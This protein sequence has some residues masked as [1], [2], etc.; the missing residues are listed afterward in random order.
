MSL[1]AQLSPEAQARLEAQKRNSTISSIAISILSIILLGLILGL[2]LL[3]VQTKEVPVL[4]TYEVPKLEETFEEVRPRPTTDK[5][6]SSPSS[7]TAKVIASTAPSAVSV[8]VPDVVEAPLSLDFGDGSD[9][10][11]GWGNGDGIGAGGFAGLPATVSKRCNAADRAK[12][13]K[14]TD[15]T[16]ACET[17][18]VKALDWFKQTQNPDGSWGKTHQSAMTGFAL[19]AYLG[20]CETPKS[21]NYGAT[22]TKGINYLVNLG[23]K[24]KG[25]L[26]VL[27]ET[28]IQWVYEHG[29]STYALAESYTFIQELKITQDFPKLKDVTKEA[30]EMIMDGQSPAGGWNYRYAKAPTGDNSVGFWQIQALKACKHT[31]IWPDSKFKRT[32]DNALDFLTKVQGQD[33]AVG[34]REDSNRSPGLTGGAVLAFQM[35]DQ[36]DHKTAK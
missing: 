33:G 8:P 5:R 21:K 16:P 19:L 25:R 11:S 27:E 3:K 6:P 28:N 30:G 32:I 4:V 35:W 17:A 15:G 24:N 12:R 13:L 31:K 2:V 18:V 20:H 14:E 36:G 9:F 26:S 29:I 7:S 23:E 22:V 34:Y 10:G 1:H